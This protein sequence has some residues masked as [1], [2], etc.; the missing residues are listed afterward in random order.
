MCEAHVALL[1][2]EYQRRA[3]PGRSKK[4]KVEKEDKLD[5]R[6]SRTSDKEEHF[7]VYTGQDV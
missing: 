7:E 4:A 1:D 6:H 5:R 3:K 2:A